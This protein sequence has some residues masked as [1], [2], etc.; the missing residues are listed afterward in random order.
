LLQRYCRRA[1]RAAGAEDI[2]Q[3]HPRIAM[4]QQTRTTA[5]QPGNAS[6]REAIAAPPP[7]P[8]VATRE[9][10]D[11]PPS[12]PITDTRSLTPLGRSLPY[13]PASA[14]HGG[15][16]S[17]WLV[18]VGAALVTALVVFAIGGVVV[19]SYRTSDAAPVGTT[20]NVAPAA[21]APDNGVPLGELVKT[22]PAPNAPD[23]KS[24]PDKAAGASEPKE[25]A[26]GANAASR[27]ASQPAKPGTRAAGNG[28]SAP[29]AAPTTPVAAPQSAAD[30][31]PGA[32]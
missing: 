14:V 21:P 27:A 8:G 32:L 19:R 17:G 13:D 10:L 20:A 2:N 30:Y 1:A 22:K 23:A 25:G 18:P 16:G 24:T 5:G 3:P 28:R 12:L 11:G 7:L 15:G 6:T 26:T 29:A 9:T 31:L 4:G